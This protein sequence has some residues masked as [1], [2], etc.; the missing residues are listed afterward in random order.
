MRHGVAVAVRGREQARNRVLHAAALLGLLA[1]ADID[2]RADQPRHAAL[3]TGEGRFVVD[4]VA[5]A[6]V[7]QR[8]G[9]FVDLRAGLGPKA[10][11]CGMHAL[12]NLGRM[13]IELMHRAADDRGARAHEEALPRLVHA[14]VIAVAALEEHRIGQRLDQLLGLSLRFDELGLAAA[15][16][17]GDLACDAVCALGRGGERPDQSGKQHADG[18]PA[19][20]RK[21]RHQ[22][23]A[24][25]AQRLARRA[26]LEVPFSSPYGEGDRGTQQVRC[27]RAATAV[28]DEFALIGDAQPELRVRMARDD[29]ADRLAGAEGDARHALEELAPRLETVD[30]SRTPVHREAQAHAA[31]A[32]RGKRQRAAR[33]DRA[34]IARALDRLTAHRVGR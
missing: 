33:D 3:R 5:L 23:V 31:L 19:G 26:E 32:V 15:Q 21:P 34:A 8:D 11:V 22:R 14:E 18:E 28:V 30:R 7:G 16:I 12:G 13:R 4:R 29:I 9:R 2:D 27:E 20:E 1:L 24:A 25:R 10:L 6:G 17:L